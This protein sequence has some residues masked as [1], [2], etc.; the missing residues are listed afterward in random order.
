MG[1]TWEASAV[2]KF[3][4]QMVVGAVVGIVSMAVF[5]Y[6]GKPLLPLAGR[7]AMLTACMGSLYVI[8]GLFVGAGAVAP[9]AG[10]HFLNVEDAD[11]LR[12]QRTM[13]SYSAVS[14]CLGGF[15]LLI[16]SVGPV[17]LSEVGR[18][19]LAVAAGACLLGAIVFGRLC[20]DRCDELMRR[21]CGEASVL[22][23]NV[24][25]MLLAGWGALAHLGLAAWITPLALLSG[26][27]LLYLL[28]SFWVVGRRGMLK[29]R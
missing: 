27:A 12:E 15:F 18:S 20:F 29:P 10:A 26:F 2:R 14:C 13:L 1:V 4:I 9:G 25:L 11:E 6:L 28:A 8:L 22:T 17:A 16:L 24:G 3:L 7:V 19:S 23:L 5:L 21:I